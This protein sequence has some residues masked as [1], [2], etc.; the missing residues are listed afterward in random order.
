M[1][2]SKLKKIDGLTKGLQNRLQKDDSSEPFEENITVPVRNLDHDYMCVHNV[3]EVVKEEETEFFEETER[4]N[5]WRV[6][7]R[8][9]ELGVLAD[10]LK[11]CNLCGQPL[12]L[13][14]C[15]GE[16]K[17]GLA[18]VL[19]IKCNFPSCGLVNEVSTGSKHKTS[20][21]G[22]AWDIN[23]KLA[24]GIAICIYLYILCSQIKFLSAIV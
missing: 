5:Q 6:G 3:N 18:H 23:T 10:G 12:H 7:R 13:S 19:Q 24:A 15:I 1:K 21:G 4:K 14:S 9:V 11:G 2:A 20:K 16:Q 17:Y 22:T 8:V